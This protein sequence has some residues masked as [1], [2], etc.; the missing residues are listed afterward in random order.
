MKFIRLLT[1]F[2][3]LL[4]TA[5]ANAFEI[6]G[7]VCNNTSYQGDL[8]AA[9]DV[10]LY[11]SA[12]QHV[13]TCEATHEIAN[14]TNREEYEV[15]YQ[16]AGFYV[17]RIFPRKTRILTGS[18]WKSCISTN[19]P[20]EFKRL[21]PVPGPRLAVQTAPACSFGFA[22]L[23]ELKQGLDLFGSAKKLATILEEEDQVTGTIRN[24]VAVET[25]FDLD[26]TGDFWEY[27]V[28]VTNPTGATMDFYL[29]G[30]WSRLLDEPVEASVEPGTSV[31]FLLRVPVG[32]EGDEP[33][34]YSALLDFDDGLDEFGTLAIP[35]VAPTE[36]GDLPVG[37]FDGDG[38][39]TLSDG[40]ALSN[41]LFGGGSAPA[42][43]TADCSGPR[44]DV[45]LLITELPTQSHPELSD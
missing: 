15:D 7:G 28:E 41:Y 10:R 34:E 11:S 22:L 20:A 37:D 13:W 42:E 35:I 16:A 18:S 9:L 1:A 12:V 5:D 44:E 4:F 33:K 32:D 6:G 45:E 17:G 19:E 26:G 27:T 21:A 31:E 23:N 25:S 40:L 36:L 30:P 3:I 39:V 43:P 14:R 2:G 24:I 29:D 38:T 8:D